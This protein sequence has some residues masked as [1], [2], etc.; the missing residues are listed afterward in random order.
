MK[1]IYSMTSE[2]QYKEVVKDAP[3]APNAEFM[4]ELVCSCCGDKIMDLKFPFCVIN[5]YECICMKCFRAEYRDNAMA[6]KTNANNYRLRSLYENAF[7]DK[8]RFMQ[9][10]NIEQQR[11]RESIKKEKEYHDFVD[12]AIDELYENALKTDSAS[13]IEI[14]NNFKKKIKEGDK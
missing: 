14:V 2:E 10:A 8:S 11:L 6:I 3:E 7:N 9:T 13:A 4:E 12:K 1:S 5:P